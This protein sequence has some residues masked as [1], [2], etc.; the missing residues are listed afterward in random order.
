M[1]KVQQAVLCVLLQTLLDQKLITQDI[2]DKSREKI[3]GT[4]DWP[5]F[6]G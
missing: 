5:E 1:E 6:F 3:L 2:H 4:L